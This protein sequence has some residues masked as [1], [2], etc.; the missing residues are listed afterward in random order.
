[1]HGGARWDV[2]DVSTSHEGVNPHSRNTTIHDFTI[3]DKIDVGEMVERI[4][5]EQTSSAGFEATRVLGVNS[6]GNTVPLVTLTHGH[7]YQ[8]EDLMLNGGEITIA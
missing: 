2:F 5:I 7:G 4:F 3:E 6:M 1:M 8:G